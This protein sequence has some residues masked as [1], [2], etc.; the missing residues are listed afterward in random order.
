MRGHWINENRD[1]E[2]DKI[3]GSGLWH[4]RGWLYLNDDGG[5]QQKTI[6]LEWC[7]GAHARH[8]GLTFNTGFVWDH[9]IHF[10]IGLWRLFCVF[11]T[12]QHPIFPHWD[13]QHGD[14]QI[15][16][17]IFDGALWIDLW[18]DD[19]KWDNRNWRTRPIVIHPMDILF[20]RTKHT[21][22]S[23]SIHEVDVALPEGKYPATVELYYSIWTRPRWPFARKI[24]RANIELRHGI[25]VPGKG[26]NSW[27]LDD[28]AILSMTCP[29]NTVEG[30]IG[31]VVESALRSR[32]RHGGSIDWKPE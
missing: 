18:R 27:D 25:P 32:R 7:F 21:Q 13:H 4:G 2:S 14:R 17:R 23:I 28:D 11:I 15:G 30:A 19:D 12:V 8:T 20:G 10:M 26:E 1:R 9:E 6:G 22:Q 24:K 16:L 31:Q 3:I 29:A 5:N